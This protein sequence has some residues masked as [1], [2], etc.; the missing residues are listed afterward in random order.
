MG[1]ILQD[2]KFTAK[3]YIHELMSLLGIAFD[4]N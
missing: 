3:N 2:L 1:F 4:I